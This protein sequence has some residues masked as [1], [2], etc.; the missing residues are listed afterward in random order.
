MTRAEFVSDLVQLSYPSKMP[1]AT[2]ALP[3][4]R[5]KMGGILRHIKGSV[6][7][8]C[9]AADTVEHA[10]LRCDAVH[11][12]KWRIGNY[13]MTGV[14]RVRARNHASIYQPGW[15]AACVRAIGKTRF[16]R[17]HDSGDVQSQRHLRNIVSV[18][19]QTPETR[20][21]MPTKESGILKRFVA[22]GGSIPDNM[23]I[24]VS[25]A[26][27]GGAPPSFWPTTS[28][29]GASI[30]KACRAYT[31]DGRCGRCRACWDSSVD[32]VDYPEH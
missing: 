1:G 13:L 30:G 24:R 10:R 17:W 11:D 15:V 29:V 20:H 22:N 4:S 18:A 23:V 31:R 21:W 19:R 6:C 7:E 28:T 12:G 5:C 3:A 27:V 16:F 25:A 32:N 14:K 2:F 26:M 9:Y 8:R